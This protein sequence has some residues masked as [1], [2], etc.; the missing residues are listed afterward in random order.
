MGAAGSVIR[1]LLGLAFGSPRFFWT[2]QPDNVRA[3]S[4]RGVA[5]GPQARVHVLPESVS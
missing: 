4:A 5:P 1:G 3:S 2:A